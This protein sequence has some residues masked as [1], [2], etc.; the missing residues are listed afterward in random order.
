MRAVRKFQNDTPSLRQVFLRLA[1]VSLHQHRA[2][3]NAFGGDANVSVVSDA[4]V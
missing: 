1:K 2:Q 4:W 3:E